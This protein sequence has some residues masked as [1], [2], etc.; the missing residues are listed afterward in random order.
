MPALFAR[1]SGE[2]GIVA[3]AQ[4]GTGPDGIAMLAN[5]GDRLVE[6][7][8][9]SFGP[10]SPRW[11]KL[12]AR[13]RAIGSV[14]HPAIRGVLALQREPPSV[15]LEGDRTPRSPSSSSRTGAT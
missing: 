5:K 6:V 3:L 8:D 9:L 10:D 11:P 12:E 1:E 7:F 13:L 15:V 2:S 4:L 14:D